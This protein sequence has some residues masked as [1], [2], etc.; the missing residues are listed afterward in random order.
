VAHADIAVEEHNNWMMD[1]KVEY[2]IANILGLFGIM[3][4][5]LV[6]LIP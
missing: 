1:G 4:Q 5:I 6:I 3:P 2:W